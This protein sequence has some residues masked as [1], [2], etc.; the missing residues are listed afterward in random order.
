MIILVIVLLAVAG[1][2]EFYTLLYALKGVTYETYTSRISVD[3][4]EEFEVVTVI[5]NHKGL[6]VPFLRVQEVVPRDIQIAGAELEMYASKGYADLYTT[7]YLAPHQRVERRLTAAM[8]ARGRYFFQGAT[9][10]GGD[11][12]GLGQAED[13]YPVYQELVVLPARAELPGL[14][15]VLGGFLGERSAQ[16]FIMEDPILTLGYREYTGREPMKSISWAQSAHTGR[17]MVKKYDFTTEVSCT[18]LL[19]VEC[20]KDMDC[21]HAAVEACFSMARTVCEELERKKIKYDFY[22]NATAAGAVGLWSQVNEGLGKT[23]LAAILEG[24]GRATYRATEPFVDTLDHACQTG[25]SG[26]GYVVITPRE[27]PAYGPGLRRL[28]ELRGGSVL[29]LTPPEGE[30]AATA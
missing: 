19:N 30:E 11:F 20:A 13:D 6:M 25:E 7:L 28:R 8:P 18:V 10:Q 26:R 14:R 16:R 4:G 3:P 2:L 23:H 1:A 22:T 29:V 27:L 9:M 12:L 21:S 5:E 17:L 24:L 15:D